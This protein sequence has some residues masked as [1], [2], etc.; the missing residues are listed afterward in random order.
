MK[1]QKQKQNT[2]EII[3]KEIIPN[4]GIGGEE[5]HAILASRMTEQDFSIRNQFG[6]YVRIG[7]SPQLYRV[8]K[9]YQ[10]MVVLFADTGECAPIMVTPGEIT[11]PFAVNENET[12]WGF[13]R[14]G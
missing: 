1:K 8:M 12:K 10:G 13:V 9:V 3:L 5:Y 6:T 7:G 4:R 14:Y 2:E 11:E